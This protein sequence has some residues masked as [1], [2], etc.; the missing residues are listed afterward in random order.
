MI[1]L[2]VEDELPAANNLIRVLSKELPEAE[3]A[4]PIA[5]VKETIAWL[6]SNP[7]PDLIFLDINLTDGPSFEVFDSIRVEAPVIFCTAYDQCALKAFELNSI[8]YLLKPLDP[9]DLKRALGKFNNWN[10][11]DESQNWQGMIKDLLNPGREFK[12]RFVIKVGDQLKIVKTVDVS[13]FESSGKD[14]FLQTESGKQLPVDESLD[15]LEPQMPAG[16][17]FRINRNYL[18]RIEAIKDV[19]TYSGTR[20]KVELHHS[21]DHDILVSRDKSSSF[22]D[23]LAGD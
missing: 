3:I 8:D 13:F 23:W 17:F 10:A 4:G 21:E 5:S 15:K 16:E 1:V 14:T 7:S 6:Q 22:K 20:L 19:R 11:K 18:I 12:Q 9:E 2:V